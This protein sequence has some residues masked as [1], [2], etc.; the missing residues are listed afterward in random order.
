MR[1]RY[2]LLACAALALG[3]A[4]APRTA[5][6]DSASIQA[7]K[8]LYDQHCQTC[9]GK[10]GKGD[11]PTGRSLQPR[12]R[13][14]QNPTEFKSKNDEEVFKVISKGGAASG[15]S[16]LMLAWAS[17]L[18]EQQIWQVIAYVRSLAPKP[19]APAAPSTK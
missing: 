5:P 3:A 18:K 11:G 6:T 2:L 1:R 7:G 19:A 12:P 13:N 10:T 8:K 15:L 14:F 17:V 4:T 16:P 9:H